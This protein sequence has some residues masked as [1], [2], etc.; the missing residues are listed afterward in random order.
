MKRLWT[1]H[2]IAH[3]S[4]DGTMSYTVARHLSNQ[5]T[6]EG[7]GMQQATPQPWEQLSR[8]L[9]QVGYDV[10]SIANLKKTLDF[11]QSDD[12]HEVL[13]DESQLRVIGFTDV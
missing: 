3:R 2:L 12:I 10:F 4:N 8:A 7:G 5:R 1:L 11:K 6:G 13:L 9:E